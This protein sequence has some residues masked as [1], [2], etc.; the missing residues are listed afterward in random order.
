MDEGL[1]SVWG[2][3]HHNGGCPDGYGLFID[4]CWLFTVWNF[5]KMKA[6]TPTRAR[7][8]IRRFSGKEA[9]LEQFD[10]EKYEITHRGNDGIGGFLQTDTGTYTAILLPVP[11]NCN[12]GR[13]KMAW[14]ETQRVQFII[15]VS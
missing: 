3:Q 11:G 5:L 4:Q 13:M 9:S 2:F 15:S 14:D 6:F 7:I 10:A 12:R 8:V 1:S